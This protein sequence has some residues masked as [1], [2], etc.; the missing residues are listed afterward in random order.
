MNV[1][2]LKRLLTTA[3]KHVDGR[4]AMFIPMVS[5]LSFLIVGYSALDKEA[6]TISTKEI[7]LAY[8]QELKVSQLVISDNH[9]EVANLAVEMDTSR[10][11][12]HRVGDYYVNV[13]VNDRCMNETSKEILVHVVDEEKTQ[14]VLNAENKDL[15]NDEGELKINVN[16]SN[17]LSQYIKAIDNADGDITTFMNTIQPLDTSKVGP[18]DVIVSISDSSG[19]YNEAKYQ[20]VITDVEA[21][22]LT[23]SSGQEVEVDFGQHFDLRDYAEISDN[24]ASFE[25]LTIEFETSVNTQEIGLYETKFT[26]TD[27]SGNKLEDSVKAEVKDLSAPV[28]MVQDVFE[29]EQGQD[30]DI[31]SHIVAAD[32]KDGDVTA[33]ISVDGYVDTNEAGEYGLVLTVSDEAGNE[34]TRHVSVIVNEPYRAPIFGS[35]GGNGS[36]TSIGLGKVGSPYVY[37]S[38]GP[39]AFDCS[40]FTSYVFAQA[41]ISIGRTT[42]AQYAGGSQ[43]SEVQPGDLL[44]FNTVGSLGHVGIYLGDGLM[45]HC[46]SEYTGVEVT[47]IYSSYWQSTYAGAVRY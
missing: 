28:I 8:G 19:N 41:G 38:A 11:D 30:F 15:M 1:Q 24:A 26:I 17:D 35:G 33:N 13:T 42:H 16:A 47:S 39:N 20:F 22:K 2:S 23:W 6:P 40:G 37:G 3:K 34:T 44:F 9:D 7:K 21:P 25:E 32:N 31:R 43:V 45:V 10:L 5:V 29:I 46:G 12:I 14:F 27:P 36:V 4:K 18:Q